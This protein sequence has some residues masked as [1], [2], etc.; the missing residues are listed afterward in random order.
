MAEPYPLFAYLDAQPVQICTPVASGYTLRR[1]QV[2]EE[3]RGPMFLGRHKSVFTFRS[4][5][6]LVAFL[7]SGEPHNLADMPDWEPPDW[8]EVPLVADIALTYTTHEQLEVCRLH[9][10]AEM[11]RRRTSV[12]DMDGEEHFFDIA[13]ISFYPAFEVVQELLQTYRIVRE[14]GEYAGLTAVLNALAPESPLEI[15]ERDLG[16]AYF[17]K[18]GDRQRLSRHDLDALASRWLKIASQIVSVVE[19]RD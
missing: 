14:V 19:F 4:T 10:V 15:F 3:H 1:Y 16:T 2:D 13:P 6:N 12:V 5:S 11:L 8:E 17:T 18:S 9:I 7:R